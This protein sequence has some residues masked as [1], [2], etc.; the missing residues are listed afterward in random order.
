MKHGLDLW[1]ARMN[2][3]I[4]EFGNMQ[5]EFDKWIEMFFM[6]TKTNKETFS[7]LCDFEETDANYLLKIDV[8]GISKDNI[9][10]EV[11]NNQLV[12]SGE[13]KEEMTK[14][15]KFRHVEEIYH[16]RFQRVFSIPTNATLDKIEASY[17]EGVLRIILP[18]TT[19]VK[20]REI[21][22]SADKST[23]GQKPDTKVSVA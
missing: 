9:K 12:V 1:K 13:R 8:P 11:L 19:V 10:V 21:K 17:N 5:D 3:M 14:E 2:P 16:G 6:K 23:G 4:K 15:T 22:V 20:S 18:K 7:P